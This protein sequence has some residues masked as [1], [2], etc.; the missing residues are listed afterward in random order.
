MLKS[1]SPF[2]TLSKNRT[3]SPP[4]PSRQ[5]LLFPPCRGNPVI[6]HVLRGSLLRLPVELGSIDPHAMQMTA[7]F[8]ATATLALR[9]PFRLASLAPQAFSPDYFGTRVSSTQDA[10]NRYMRSMA[11]PHFEIWPD[12]SISPGKHG[13]WSS[14]RYRPQHFSHR[15][16]RVGSSIVALKQSAVIGPTPGA[17]MNRRTCAS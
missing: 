16:K 6:P 14:I 17:V 13:V 5:G 8:R 9:R 7:S 12:Q 4:P 2:R 10:L 11:S 3:I 15:L 1:R